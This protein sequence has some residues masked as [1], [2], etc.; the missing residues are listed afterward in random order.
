MK[1]DISQRRK[2]Y[3]FHNI[4]KI[5]GSVFAIVWV[6]GKENGHDIDSSLQLQL[7]LLFVVLAATALLV[8]NIRKPFAIIKDNMLVINAVSFEKD[9]IKRM[10]Y[11]VNNKKKHELIV[12]MEGYSDWKI[13]LTE[14]YVQINDLAVYHFIKNNFYPLE[15]KYA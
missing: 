11:L 14:E 1:L 15:L 10:E 12:S 9:A 13:E 4:L 3:F 6:I 5:A 7:A 2:S 8:M